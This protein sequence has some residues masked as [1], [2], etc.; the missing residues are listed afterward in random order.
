MFELH[1]NWLFPCN[2]YPVK[3]L[4]ETVVP[5]LYGPE[6]GFALAL[7]TVGGLPHSQTSEKGKMC[8]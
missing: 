3:Q 5:Q 6:D 1:V 2:V 4:Y 8:H 7:V